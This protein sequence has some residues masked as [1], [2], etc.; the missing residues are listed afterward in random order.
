M[1]QLVGAVPQNACFP[2][3]IAAC[4]GRI[5]SGRGPRYPGVTRRKVPFMSTTSIIANRAQPA[6]VAA[7]LVAAGGAA[8]ILGAYYFQ[9]VLHYVPC[10]LCLQQRIPYYVGIP[11]AI[12]V[13]LA[14]LFNAPRPLVIGGLALLVIAMLIGAGLGAYHAGV[15]WHLWEGPRDCGGAIT[16]FGNA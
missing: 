5:D 12:A 2:C 1:G 4:C 9:Y 11:L 8:T 7:F 10:E 3:R 16:S 15:E 6:A 14:A 13:A